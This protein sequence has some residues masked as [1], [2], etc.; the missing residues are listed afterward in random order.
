MNTPSPHR[1]RVKTGVIIVG[2]GTLPL[3]I[4]VLVG[5]KH[6]N[7]VGLGM[8]M[9]LC[10]LVGGVFIVTGL[11]GGVVARIRRNRN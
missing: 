10:W 8:L 11:F 3:L 1:K 4:Y 6:G 7:P 9:W 2:A 5:P